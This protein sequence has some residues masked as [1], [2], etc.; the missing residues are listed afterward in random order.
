VYEDDPNDPN[1]LEIPNRKEPKTKV[2]F[3]MPMYGAKIN[4]ETKKQG[5]LK[6]TRTYVISIQCCVTS[7]YIELMFNSNTDQSSFFEW[8]KCIKESEEILTSQINRL[9]HVQFTLLSPSKVQNYKK[10]TPYTRRK[11]MPLGKICYSSF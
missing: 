11:P 1:F 10:A 3:E 7:Q 2:L 6:L 9:C 5:L 8:N 4:M